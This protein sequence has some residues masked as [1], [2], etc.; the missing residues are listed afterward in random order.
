MA[1]AQPV[2]VHSGTCHEIGTITDQLQS[3]VPGT[4]ITTI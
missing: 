2:H 4:S 1:A 3:V